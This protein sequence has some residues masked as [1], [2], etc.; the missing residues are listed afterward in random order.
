MRRKRSSRIISFFI[1]LLFPVV[2]TVPFLSGETITIPGDISRICYYTDFFYNFPSDDFIYYLNDRLL[3]SEKPDEVII[4]KGLRDRLLEIISWH[5]VIKEFMF[6]QTRGKGAGAGFNLKD[7][8]GY[9]KAADVLNL[10]GQHLKKNKK[11]QYYLERK[12]SA[13]VANYL[14]F[15]LIR[16]RVMEQQ[17]NR[18]HSFYF[19][20]KESRVAI[21]WDLEFIR[22]VSGVAVDA[23]SFFEAL[24]KNERLSLLLGV[25]YRLSDNEINYIDNL[26]QTPRFG[27]WKKIYNDKKLLMGLYVLANALRVKVG[28]NRLE[29]PG[30]KAAESFWTRMAGDQ[31]NPSSFEFLE[32][33]ATKDDGKLNY[34]YVFS[35]FLPD[36][37]LK[38]LFFDFNAQKMKEIYDLISLKE[39]AKINASAFP[40]LDDWNFFTLLYALRTKDG[41]LDFP[42][43]VE[44]WLEAVRGGEKGETSTFFDLMKEVSAR[45]GNGNRMS[46]TR[47]FM[48]LYSKFYH[49][50]QLL[51]EGALFKLYTHYEKFNGLVD[52]IEK[53]PIKKPGTVSLLVDWVQTLEKL[54]KKEE[55][56]FT[57]IY[58]SLFEVL[59]F[60]GKYAP[61]G[62][63]YDHLVSELVKLPLDRA[64]FYRRLFQFF[65]KELGMKGTGKTLMDVMLNG[66]KNPTL[67]IANTRYKYFIKDK[68]KK[69]LTDILL[70]QEVCSFSTL[71]EIN[72][73]FDEGLRVKPPNTGEIGSRIRSI[74]RLLPHP[75][76]SDDAPRSIRH[77]VIAYSPSK[78]NKVVRGL[79]SK[80]HMGA[81][82]DA[83]KA[84]LDKIKG[85]Y[86][87]Y[88][89]KDHLMALAYAVNA[90]DAGLKSFLN[91]NLV[92][93]HDINGSKG[94]GPWDNYGKNQKH[95]YFSEYH[96]SGGLSRLNIALAAKWKEHLFRNNVIHN[97]PQ[98][99]ALIINLMDFYP[100]P[101]VN[102][103][104]T[105]N[106]L[107]VELGLALI[108]RAEDN[109]NDALKKSL[110]EKISRVTSGYHYRRFVE[111]LDGKSN[112]HNLFF[113]EIKALAEVFFQHS[114]PQKGE[115][116]WGIPT[117]GKLEAFSGPPLSE[118]LKK[119]EHRFGS[120]YSH[121]FG[122]LRPQK[123]PLFPQEVANL[124]SSGWLSGE[125]MDEF[126]VKLA[127]HLH[128]KKI[129]PDLLGQL[130]YMY[131]SKTC[132]RF[133]RQ[134][135][136][137]DYSAAYLIFKIFNTSHLNRQI[138]QLKKEG[139]LKLK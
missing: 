126:K 125:M 18:T 50:R 107:L 99:Y 132:R 105:Y 2:F 29:L 26:V 110:M 95:R 30:G 57:E 85:G 104:L 123:I 89:L 117:L 20:L 101:L 22:E 98:I 81:K 6:N 114:G 112:H 136:P 1:I 135:H 74:F 58:Q 23:S 128:K 25:L 78:L 113:S 82:Q 56:L 9:R 8:G 53:L 42:L 96:L 109:D 70:S 102:H 84:S 47:K 24:L 122:N 35:Y 86:L 60:T 11:G 90:K 27:A 137:Y 75:G 19:R 61:T 120:I 54:D 116:R 21:P 5:Q 69:I 37:T 45:P 12:R 73:L 93:L 87:I 10:L 100:V 103:S 121:T 119:E 43:G 40:R 62:F 41:T 34:L 49:R 94:A 97:S 59:S 91:P 115:N 76:I 88:Q 127:Y 14:R 131:L 129:P 55:I 13:G 67:T 108:S 65:N 130:L 16:P 92:R 52:F 133:L 7:P 64:Q 106:G 66:I 77:R 134:N 46:E 79:T 31:L 83:L 36:K 32:H 33:L 63:D 44:A 48:T 39:K 138:K 51:A 38:A 139:Y 28:E 3:F 68:F 71:L 72:R 80:I 118:G 15:A 111:Y 124:F 4:E 17:M